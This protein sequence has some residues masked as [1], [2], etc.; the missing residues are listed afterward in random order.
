MLRLWLSLAVDF[1]GDGPPDSLPN[2]DLKLVAGDAIA[3]PDPRMVKGSATAPDSQ[4]MD[5]TTSGIDGSGLRENIAA[6]TNA[7]GRYKAALKT[8]VEAIKADLRRRIPGAAP[9]DVVDWRIDFADVMLNGGFD[10]VIANPPY[11]ITVNDRRSAAIGHVDS[12]T[13]FMGLACDLAPNG[14]SP[15]SRPLRGK[16]WNGS[17]SSV[18]TC[19]ATWLCKAW[20]IYRMTCLKSPMWT[21]QSRLRQLGNRRPRSFA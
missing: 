13:N 20:S 6:C 4:Q 8:K 10:V 7:Q 2:L 19:S 11:G 16:R 5:F 21:R 9:A 12:Y 14:V 18:S 1:D 15:T 3:G 17:K